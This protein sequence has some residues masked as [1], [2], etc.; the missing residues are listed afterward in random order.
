MISDTVCL[1]ADSTLCVT[2]AEFFSI[3]G[4][5][6]QFDLFG[7]LGL[8]PNFPSNGPNFMGRMIEAGILAEPIISFKYDLAN[9]TSEALFGGINTTHFIGDLIYY[10]LV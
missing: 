2:A 10:D 9:G 1:D 6:G 5:S 7:I 4:V 8:A 3:E